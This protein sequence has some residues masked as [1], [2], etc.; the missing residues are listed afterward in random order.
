MTELELYKF[1]QRNN[2]EYNYHSKEEIYLFIPFGY[3][4]YDFTKL[5]D[6]TFFDDGG[7]EVTL[8]KDYIAVNAVGICEY[9]DLDC[10]NIFDPNCSWLKECE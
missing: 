2:L 5:L 10:D 3:Y 4:L 7:Y 1:V 8:M 9:Y 6:P